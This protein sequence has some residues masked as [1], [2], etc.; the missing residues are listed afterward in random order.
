MVFTSFSEAALF[1]QRNL[2]AF[3][4]NN[5][6][7]EEESRWILFDAVF[8][9]ISDEMLEESLHDSDKDFLQQ[10]GIE[11]SMVIYFIESYP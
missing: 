3:D 6:L 5:P 9:K 11:E 4:P 1:L 8:S 7:D 10:E 2:N